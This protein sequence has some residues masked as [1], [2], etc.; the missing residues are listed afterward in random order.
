MDKKKLKA[1]E[2]RFLEKYPGGFSHPDMVAVGKKHKMEQM[3][4]L[5]QQVFKKR[6]FA[7]P[8]AITNAM[9]QTISRASMVSLFEKPKFR[10][11]VANAEAKVIN[12]LSDG[13][14]H[15]LHGNQA[16]GFE[17]LAATLQQQNLAKWSLLTIVPNYYRPHEEVFVKPTTAKGVIECFGLT[18]LEYKPQPTWEF[19]QA[20]RDAILTMRSLVHPSIAPNNA[21]FC[22]FLMRSV[23]K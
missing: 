22:G 15:F 6:S 21:A 18:G 11:M 1:A 20:Y 10:D 4:A 14:K 23:A 12:R 8:F 13:L 3:V 16:K 9:V 17:Q 2:R 5:A 7:D 19:Y